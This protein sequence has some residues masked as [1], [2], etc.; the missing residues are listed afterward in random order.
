[1]NTSRRDF[2]KNSAIALTGTALLP[3][4]GYGFSLA[5]NKTMLAVQLYCVR[6][7]M[8]EDPLAS[9]GQLATMGYTHV[10]H[11]NYVDHKFYGW[12]A[13]EFKKV[14]DGLG[15][16]I[17]S[18]HT[19]L[20]SKHWDET[21]RD[22]TDEWKRTIEDAAYIGQGFVISPYM[23]GN[24]HDTYDSFSRFMEV[25]N[26]SGALCQEYGMKFGY[27]NHDFEFSKTL[28]GVT[29][30]DLIMKNTDAG[31][32]VMQLDMGNMYKA[33]AIAKDLLARYPGRY[34]TIH[35]KDMIR[36]K[37]GEYESCALGKGMIDVKKTIDLARDQ[38]TTLFIIEQ[39][40]YQGKTPMERMK[41]NLDAMHTWGYK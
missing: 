11:A 21:R 9:L 12:T 10:E 6:D 22:F 8:E 14:L 5:S 36:T 26:R 2:I 27:H 13:A 24:V 29:L 37:D 32:V 23:E 4:K 41:E 20:R 25:F 19:V 15:L 3:E 17:P 31:K 39:E 18:G 34:D 16:K 30:W 33:G 35:V 38:G 7:E 1:M 40:A 28:K